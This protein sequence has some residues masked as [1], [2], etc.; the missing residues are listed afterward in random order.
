[1]PT[2]ITLIPP[3]DGHYDCYPCA[4]RLGNGDLFVAFSRVS[5]PQPQSACI[6]A[7]RS[8]DNGK[9]WS[10][11]AILIA[12][13]GQLDYDPNIVAW[14]NKVL[15]IATTVPL[16][17][18]QRVT[19]SV[20]NAVRSEDCGRTWSAPTEIP[21]PPYVY[22]SG[23]INAGV[24]FP[25]GTLAFA[26]TPDMRI[27]QGEAVHLDGDMW[28]ESALMLSTDD[29]HTWRSSASVKLDTARPEGLRYAA[30]GLD[31]PALAL[32]R[33]GSLYLLMRTGLE[34]LYETR[35]ADQG[36]TWS[37]ARPSALTAHNC[38]A[39]LCVFDH[40][41][42][43]RGWL[44]IYDHSPTDRFPLAVA[45]SLDEGQTWSKPHIV[46]DVGAASSYP[47][48]V[49]TAAGPILLVWQQDI[50]DSTPFRREIQGCLLGLD[51]MESI[52]A[53]GTQEV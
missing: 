26:Y 7:V 39:E 24:R 42:L 37:P 1:M 6:A 23:K 52:V 50:A 32:C 30:N 15:V 19:T 21:H 18:G 2:P 8:S 13:P 35:T 53:A 9:T 28:G 45:V 40:P 14:E 49:Q 34:R 33:D 47:A 16:T 29:G 12:T 4:V 22:C 43:G 25:D 38:P 48:C 27:Q 11:P 5:T 46:A 31:E 10:E 44:A 17:H 3:A 51:E 36:R 20:F 41:R